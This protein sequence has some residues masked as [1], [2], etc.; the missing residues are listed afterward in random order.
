[1]LRN[2]KY[3]LTRLFRTNKILF[4]GVC[5]FIFFNLFFNLITKSQITPIFQWSMYSN[6]LPDQKTYSILEIRYNENKLL[7]F[8]HTWE[9][10]RKVLF[11]NTSGLYMHH[12]LGGGDYAKEHYINNWLPNHPFFNRYLKNFKNYNDENDYLK[13]PSWLKRYLEQEVGEKIYKI[14]LI[15]VEASFEPS[16]KVNKLSSLLVCTL[17]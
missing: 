7:E 9:E 12:L 5:I 2:N 17:Q 1:M 16:G 4:V 11:T 15:K 13:F 3:Y 14:D 8:P 6:P 10:P